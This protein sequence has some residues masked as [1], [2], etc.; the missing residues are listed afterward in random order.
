MRRNDSMNSKTWLPLTGIVLVLFAAAI[1]LL[2]PRAQAA[3]PTLA[4][5]LSLNSVP[6]CADFAQF[7]RIVV[8][9]HDYGYLDTGKKVNLEQYKQNLAER[10]HKMEA[11]DAVVAA[12]TDAA[13]EIWK[14]RDAQPLQTANE[15]SELFFAQCAASLNKAEQRRG[16]TEGMSGLKQG[17]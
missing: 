3:E 6:Q 15:I 5:R 7:A 17:L 9:V 14:A 11:P 1:M 2:S 16:S 10:G 4:E 13:E 8:N 12:L